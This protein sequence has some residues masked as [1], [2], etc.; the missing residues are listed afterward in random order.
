VGQAFLPEDRQRE[1]DA[2]EPAK[3]GDREDG[4]RRERGLAQ[5]ARLQQRVTVAGLGPHFPASKQREDDDATAKADP[6]PGWPAS[7]LAF[8]ERDQQQEQ[9]AGQQDKADRVEPALGVDL[10]TRQPPR[11]HW[12]RHCADEEVDEEDAIDQ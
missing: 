12:D 11:R 8:D 1:E 7:F 2:A 4:P 3:E 6:R 10:G 9:S 5:Q